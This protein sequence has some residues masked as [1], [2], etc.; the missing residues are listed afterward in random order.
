MTSPDVTTATYA[1]PP[2]ANPTVDR[3]VVGLFGCCALVGAALAPAAGWVWVSV[4]NPPTVPLASNGGLYLGEQAL[5]QQVGVTLWFLVVGAG[6][7]AVAGLV[8][9]WFGQRFGWRTVFAVLVL[10]VIGSVGSRYLGVHVFGPDQRAEATGATVGTPVQLSVQLDTW[11]AYLGWPIGG[12]LGV[13]GAIAGWSRSESPPQT[14]PQS[15]TLY[16]PS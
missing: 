14:P 8:V 12:L 13:L 16:S 1:E 5:N 15:P 10:C 3:R 4:A 2:P 7:G 11:V 6:F 9:G